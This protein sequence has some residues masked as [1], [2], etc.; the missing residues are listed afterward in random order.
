MRQFGWIGLS[1]VL[2]VGCGAPAGPDAQLVQDA[3]AALGGV[4][5]IERVG[6]LTVAG[7][8][9]SY[10]LG[11]NPSPDANPPNFFATFS[12]IFD[13]GNQ[14]F[15]FEE[16]RTPRF[17]TPNDATARVV[18]AL[19]GDVAFDTD[20]FDK[21]T[22]Q[23]DHLVRTRHG[24]LLHHPVGVLQAALDPGATVSGLRQHENFEVV[25]ITTA[26][27]IEV[28]LFVDRQSKRP[29]RVTSVG[30]HPM[31]GDTE[32]ETEFASY[33][34]LDGLML[35]TRII[36]RVDGEMVGEVRDAIN[37]VNGE[38]GRLDA[39]RLVATS[40]PEPPPPLIEAELL[41]EGVWRIGA[42]DYFSLLIEFSDHLLLIDI[43]ISEAYTLGLFAKAGELVPDKPLT[44]VVVSHHHFDHS[45]GLRAAVAEG[46]TL[47][48]HEPVRDGVGS[49][50]AGGARTRFLRGTREFFEE[51][52]EREHTI[53]PDALAGNP[54]PLQAEIVSGKHVI[55]DDLRT[56]ELHAITESRYADTLLMAYLPAERLLYEADVYSPPQDALSRR[57][58]YFPFAPNLFENVQ[59][60]ELD[61]E[62]V[63]PAHGPVVPFEDLV[64]A[65]E[66]PFERPQ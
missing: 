48:V 42:A 58:P 2:L 65:A 54:Q 37:E 14:R 40:S 64:K 32:L 50:P 61:V 3:A 13:W 12:R 23:P 38:I 20:P 9:E 51:L 33:R 45:G 53:A 46:M 62:R 66:S 21:S 41:S 56:V 31:L 7:D 6:T 34:D 16:L 24:E 35:P 11:E 29:A 49:S 57:E 26:D 36:W 44:H 4:G 28:T 25:D 30:A 10:W 1:A 22:R 39:P 59:K 15:R 18:T 63:A 8:G 52:V 5:A 55:E 27:G 43:P 17:V 47:L 60:L 19:D